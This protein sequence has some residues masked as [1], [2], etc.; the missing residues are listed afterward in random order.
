MAELNKRW[1]D[2]ALI[3]L[4]VLLFKTCVDA[5]E[6]TPII[7]AAHTRFSLWQATQRDP[8][9]G[10]EVGLTGLVP[11]VERRTLRAETKPAGSVLLM[12]SAWDS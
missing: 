9:P 12:I 10:T 1:V 3:V 11:L 5:I 7:R 2:A 8:R 4:F 6:Q